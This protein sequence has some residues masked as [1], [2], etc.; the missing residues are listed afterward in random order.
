MLLLYAN[1]FLDLGLLRSDARRALFVSM[2]VE[3]LLLYFFLVPVSELEQYKA[4]RRSRRSK[5]E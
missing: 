5:S 3:G 1:D 2:A 4:E